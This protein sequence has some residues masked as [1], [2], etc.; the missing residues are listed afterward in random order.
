MIEISSIG[1][2]EISSIGADG[3]LAMILEAAVLLVV[4]WKCPALLRRLRS[5][6]RP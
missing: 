6:K 5:K 4:A 2:E 3:E 1:A